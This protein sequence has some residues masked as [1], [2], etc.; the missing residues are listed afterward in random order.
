MGQ[1]YRSSCF[2][3]IL[4]V[5]SPQ[6]QDR[7][8]DRVDRFLN[9][10]RMTEPS[11][12]VLV[13]VSGGLDSVSLLAALR[14]L[15]E[16]RDLR[17]HVA[18]LDH[19]IRGSASAGDAAFVLELA[20]R[21]D[22]P[23]HSEAVDTPR[24]AAKSKR[25]LEEAARDARKAFLSRV[26][27]DIGA[28]RI[29]TA[30][31]LDDQAETVLLRLFRGSG[32]TG[33]AG[34]RPISEDGRVIRPFLNVSRQE[35]RAYAAAR[36]L[37]WREDAT[38][39]DSTYHRNRIRNVVMPLLTEAFDPR[40][41]EAVYRA[42][43]VLQADDD[44]LDQITLDASK[45]VICAR[46]ERKIALDGP[47]FFGY[48]VA[49]QRRLIRHC[50]GRV[51]HDPRRVTF[52]LIDRL[53]T[54]F[55]R[56]PGFVQVTTDLTASNTGRLILLGAEAPVFEEP[57]GL[58]PNQIDAIDA[59]LSVDDV[60]RPEFPTR[61]SAI[62]PF[63][64][65]FDREILP[66]NLVMRT[67]RPGDRIRPF[68][69]TGSRKVH[70]VLIDRKVPRLIRDEVPVLAD[71]DEVHWIVGIRAGE[72]SRVPESAQGAARFTFEGSWRTLYAAVEPYT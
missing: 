70:D 64:V 44:A 2:L 63:E 62:P 32:T 72:S 54:R 29:A 53:L 26:A 10:C 68:G 28:D 57:I 60:L 40:V 46:S 30:H 22:L 33:L 27:D 15:A 20:D 47:A 69:S 65:W 17:L 49:V 59:K 9:T 55:K 61:F 3:Y 51:G 14:S 41:P 38:N 21:Y 50:L 31:H 25:S 23:C 34:I 13:A 5:N 37:E 43:Q 36:A 11:D 42:A 4:A 39:T 71:R 16:R 58:G 7:F 45:T 19:G 35:I 24:L 1:R 52:G 56:G 18:H 12:T 67:V 66:K 6:P 48:H 8:H